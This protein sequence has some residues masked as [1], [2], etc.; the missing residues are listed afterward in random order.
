MASFQKPKRQASITDNRIA[1]LGVAMIIGG[2]LVSAKLFYMQVIQHSEYASAAS[3]RQQISK[4]LLPDRGTI[5]IR[6]QNELYPLVLD[7][8]YYLLY[9]EPKNVKD[10][11]KVVDGITPILGLAEEEWK[12]IVQKISQKNDPYE[13]L[14]HKVSEEQKQKIQALKLSG[15]GFEPEQYRDYPEKEIGGHIFGFVSTDGDTRKGQYGIE[16]HFNKELS[17]Q[18]GLL[19]SVRDALGALVTIGPREVQKATNGDDIILTID[20]AVQFTACQKL[21]H[22]YEWFKAEGGSVIIMEPTGAIIAMCNYPDFEPEKYREVENIFTFNNLSI[23]N[24]FE[25]G[26]VF[27]AITMAV[28]LD[29]NAVEPATTY[30][31]E[32]EIKVGG[33]TIKNSDLEAHG[34]QTMTQ[35]LEKSLNTGAIFVEQKV[36]KDAFR[37]YVHNFGFGK[38]TGIELDTESA[39]DLSALD[40]RGEIFGMTAS[41]GQGITATP[42][43]LATAF[44]VFANRGV[45]VKPYI[46]SEIRRA[47]GTIETFGPQEVRQVIQP[48]TAA[49]I[50]GMLTSVV[51]NSYSQKAKVQGYYLGGKSGTAQVAGSSGT[52][53]SKTNQ[54]FIGFGPVSNPRFV[55]LVSLYGPQ[56]VRFAEGSSVPLFGELAQY[57]LNYYHV[58]PDY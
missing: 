7:R 38:T 21:K 30:I 56:G 55:I 58:K 57:L 49:L 10:V 17:G 32:G 46:V 4:K 14:H 27:K 34:E 53:T 48:K 28:G 18:R 6:E 26:S 12:E 29:K 19:T 39:G 35:V 40:K 42:I 20:R 13:P 33:Y 23:F 45:L 16:G 24:A 25:P 43:Q 47:D 41:F 54:S 9:A 15:I 11:S 31:D 5:Y 1:I 3:A 44:S 52:Y 22:Y 51:E 50:S 36:G 8:D 2:V 37:E